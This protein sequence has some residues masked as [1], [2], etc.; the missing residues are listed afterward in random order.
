MEL[1][2]KLSNFCNSILALGCTPAQLIEHVRAITPPSLPETR[3]LHFLIRHTTIVV[4]VHAITPPSL[5]ETRKLHFLPRHT[6]MVPI[7]IKILPTV[8]KTL[9]DGPNGHVRP[10]VVIASYKM[11]LLLAGHPRNWT[12]RDFYV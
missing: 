6:A 4:H 1:F 11:Q 2:P 3:K 12:A 8:H 9:Q 7:Y 5:P 10:F